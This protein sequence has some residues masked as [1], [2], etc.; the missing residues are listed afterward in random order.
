MFTSGSTGTPIPY[1]KTWGP[2][3]ACVREESR[4]LGLGGAAWSMLATVPPQHMYGFESSVL[5]ALRAAT[6]CAPSGPSTRPTSP[7]AWPR[8]RA[9]GR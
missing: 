8:C 7:A 6:R 3:V 5:M 2:L 9:R 1:R 4:R